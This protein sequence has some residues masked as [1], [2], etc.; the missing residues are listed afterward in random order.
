MDLNFTLTESNIEVFKPFIPANKIAA[1]E[2]HLDN[3]RKSM[4]QFGWIP[5]ASR[6]RSKLFVGIKIKSKVN[7]LRMTEEQ[8]STLSWEER[9]ELR[10]KYDIQNRMVRILREASMPHRDDIKNFFDNLPA[11]FKEEDTDVILAWC[12]FKADV[13][14]IHKI[15]DQ[16]RPLPVFTEAGLSPRVHE[17]FSLIGLE[18]GIDLKTIRF[19]KIIYVWKTFQK[20]Q[21]LV[22][23]IVWPEKTQFNKSRFSAWT[24]HCEACGKAIPS[25]DFLPI[26]A[27]GK[28][29][30]PYALI[31]GR[32]CAKNLFGVKAEGFQINELGIRIK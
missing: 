6:S 20:R 28:E 5:H 16:L 13:S 26:V 17:T 31:V 19:P 11:N 32:D 10:E 4:A 7:I 1:F 22:P 9:S 23:V 3:L 25:G 21:I 15:L 27:D 14:V 12:K 18:T 8:R 30:T 29:G 2:L 24:G